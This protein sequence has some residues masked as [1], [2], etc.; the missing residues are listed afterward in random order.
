[1]RHTAERMPQHPFSD[2][3]LTHTIAL[4]LLLNEE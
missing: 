1:M 2:T 4:D 3:S